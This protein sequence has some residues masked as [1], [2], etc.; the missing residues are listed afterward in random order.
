MAALSDLVVSLSADTAALR[1]GLD[2]ATSM[3]K[4]FGSGIS[5]IQ[6]QIEGFGELKGVEIGK[7]LIEGLAEFVQ[8]GAEAAEQA[9]KLAQA[10]GVPVESFSRLSYAASLSNVSAEDFA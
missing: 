3:L 7:E 2:Q 4:S 8:K 5:S 10:A 1:A 9:G 6:K